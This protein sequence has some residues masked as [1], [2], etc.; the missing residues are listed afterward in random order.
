VQ[1]TDFHRNVIHAAG[2]AKEF[3]R[4]FM[5]ILDTSIVGGA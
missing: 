4:R 1:V 3:L 5:I 2:V